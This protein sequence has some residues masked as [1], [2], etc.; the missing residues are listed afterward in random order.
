LRFRLLFS[1]NPFRIPPSHLCAKH[2]ARNATGNLRRIWQPGAL[3]GRL[4]PLLQQV[5]Q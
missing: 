3:L 1:R 4:R 2:K 5:S